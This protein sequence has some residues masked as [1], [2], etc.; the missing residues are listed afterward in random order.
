MSKQTVLC[1]QKR[2]DSAIAAPSFLQSD[3]DPVFAAHRARFARL[4]EEV[5]Q[6]QRQETSSCGIGTLAEKRLHAII[7][8]YLCEDTDRHEVGVLDTRYISD[9]RIGNEVF[10]VQTG[11]F[12]P[13][14][15]K[16]A[17]YL[18]HTDCIVTIVHPIPV[19]KF[20]CWVD[21]QTQEIGKRKKSPKHTRAEALLPELYCLLPYLQ[22][23]RL[24]VQLLML[25]VQDFRLLNGRSRDRKKGS[26]RYERIP[27][28]LLG[29]ILFSTPEDFRCFLSPSLPPVFTVKDFSNTSGIRG[30]D[31]YSAVRVL[32]ALGLICQAPPIGRAMAFSIVAPPPSPVLSSVSSKRKRDDLA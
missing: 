2:A 19:N 7:K 26:T 11:A 28:A 22:H 1:K 21:P 29:E 5:A 10:E 30:R 32:E 13:M 20:V 25:E 16:I 12:Y 4:C 23:P 15:K 3:D 31:A 6:K 17:Y 27:T 24:H 18:E 14:R 8:R 9:V